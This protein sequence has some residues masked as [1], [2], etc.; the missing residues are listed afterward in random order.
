MFSPLI[1]LLPTPLI[2]P[3]V[4]PWTQQKM[5]G[6]M[7]IFFGLA[8]LPGL[9]DILER[10][11]LR[12]LG[13][14]SFSLYLTHFPLLFTLT[15]AGFILFAPEMSYGVAVCVATCAGIACSLGAATVFERWV[16]RPAIALSRRVHGLRE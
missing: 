2:G 9:Q 8:F 13:R 1:G 15:S 14:I 7:E 4:D 10:P 16:D 3:P 5:I 12:W 11:L 6:A